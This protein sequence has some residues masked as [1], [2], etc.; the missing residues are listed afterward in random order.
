V[1]VCVSAG[2][3]LS[4]PTYWNQCTEIP[5]ERHDDGRHSNFVGLSVV[6]IPSQHQNGRK[7]YEMGVNIEV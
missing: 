3:I 1:C 6:H 2:G 7:I 4:V 5:T